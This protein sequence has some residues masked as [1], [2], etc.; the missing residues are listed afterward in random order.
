MARLF[1]MDIPNPY[2]GNYKLLAVVPILMVLAS[3]Y[4]IFVSP[5]IQKGVDFK[6]GILVTLHMNGTISPEELTS[7]LTADGF[8]VVEIKSLANP[9]GSV[10]EIELQRNAALESA[11]K[12]KS[13]FYTQYTETSRLES[14]M[15]YYNDS[16]TKDAYAN[17]KAKLDA[18]ANGMF[19]LSGSGKTA[20]LFGTNVL[21]RNAVV[22]EWKGISD[23]EN[24]ALRD[25][26]SR[27]VTY[28]TAS[29]DEVTS[30]LSNK[31]LD[32]AVQ[33]V[34]WSS[35]L[36][37]IVVFIIFR[38][39]VPSVAVLVG[40][41]CDVLIAMGA[42][43]LFG[44]PLT[45]A[46]F[47]ALLMLIGFSLDT[48]VLLTMRVIKRKEGH[49]S[50]RAYEAMKTGMT[51]SL[52]SIVAFGS[53]FVLATLTNIRI[54]HEIS[55]VALAGLVGDIFATWFLNAVIILHYAEEQEK[56]GGMQQV[57]PITSLL[58]RQ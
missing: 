18:I 40:A 39:F 15:D 17:A 16:A 6:G 3:L 13:E 37:T 29:F 47:A 10:V 4:L 22:S 19:N 30:S 41:L 7:K 44:L 52:A 54:Y 20:A 2:K 45:L 23:R 24:V 49:A 25:S 1:S 14:N 34:T 21:L 38:T 53:L 50:D 8:K 43:A 28:N 58:F 48:D 36:A 27:H 42:M 35:I 11:E 33:I 26:L 12:L 55:S 5:T 9:G 51:M 56:K 57:K 46:S 32:S 31:F